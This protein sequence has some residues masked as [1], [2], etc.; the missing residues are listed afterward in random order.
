LLDY[1]RSAGLDLTVENETAAAGEARGDLR[2]RYRERLLTKP[3]PRIE[4]AR[5]AALIDEIPIL[6]V[7]GSQAVGGLE[8]AGAQELRVKETDRI[9][10]LVRNLRAMGAEVEEQTDGLS[11]A[12]GARLCGAD[13]DTC[14]D[15]R[16]A[17]A[18]AIAGLA[19]QGE[20]RI[21]GA[22]CADVSYPGFF[23]RLS[24][25]TG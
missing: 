17:M 10:A 18:F 2:V 21:H 15:H 3:L 13:I 7:L 16:I 1:L 24:E 22:E 12:G 5:T 6:T 4:G 11:V 14:G 25:V 8:V 19:A 20:T 9:A 23:D